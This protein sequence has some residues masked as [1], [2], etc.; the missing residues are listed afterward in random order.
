ME[1]ILF[2][3]FSKRR[4]WC[5]AFATVYSRWL[6][7][8]EIWHVHGVSFREMGKKHSGGRVIRIN[9]VIDP[10]HKNMVVE[11]LVEFHCYRFSFELKK[12]NEGM[13]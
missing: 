5:N 9:E 8:G 7:E 10:L 3:S 1:S 11:V 13:R 12:E 4:R 2:L 6:K